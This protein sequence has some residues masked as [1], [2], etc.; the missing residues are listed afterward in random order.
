Q[1]LTHFYVGLDLGQVSDYSAVAVIERTTFPRT[2]DPVQYSCRHLQRWTLGTGYPQ[3]VEDVTTM[4][5]AIGPSGVPVLPGAQ[6]VIDA[7]GVGR[8]IVDLFRT[9]PALH[10]RIIPVAST[11]GQSH[12]ATF[13]PR[14][15]YFNVPKKELVGALQAPLQTG[16]L[17]VARAIP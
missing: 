14:T 1:T 5:D 13:D 16:R 17:K 10:G 11:G 4:I 9:V 12:G 2:R 6:L 3:I 7:Q 15:A 8:G